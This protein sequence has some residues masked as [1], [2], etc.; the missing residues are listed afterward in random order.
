MAETGHQD[1]W[2]R[3]TL[4]AALTGGSLRRLSA[5]ADEVERWVLA[6]CPEG[7]RVER[8]RGL[9][10]G[11]ARMTSDEVAARTNRAEG[12]MSAGRMRRVDEAV[13]AVLSDAIATDLKDPAWVS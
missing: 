5:A 9:G 6:R 1:L 13:R 10:G 12:R 2:Q 7:A 11:S 4:T 8:L 3:A